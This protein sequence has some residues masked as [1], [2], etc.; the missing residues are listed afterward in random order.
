MSLQEIVN[1]VITQETASIEQAGFSTVLILGTNGNIASRTQEFTAADATLAA[2][3]NGGVNAAEY[4]A[5]VDLK[6]QSPC[7]PTFKIGCIG[8]AKV[9][10]DDAG[11]YTAGDISLDINGTTITESFDTDKDTT[12]T[13]LAATIQALASV[14]TAV[15]AA[16]SHTITITPIA[17]AAIG[18]TNI[19]LTGITGTMVAIAV[20]TTGAATETITNALN[21]IITE[22]TDWYGLVTV[23]RTQADQED[24][25][26]WVEAN[27]RLYFAGDNTQN[28]FD[29]TDALDSTTLPAV[30]KAAAYART[31]VVATLNADTEYPDAALF[32]KLLPLTPG[33]YTAKFKTLAS[34]TADSLTNAQSVNARDKNA[35]TDEP[36]AGKNIIR[37]GTVAEGEYIDIIIFIDWLKARIQEEVYAVLVKNLKVPYTPAGL[38]QIS[39][40]I[41][42]VLRI[43]QN[44]GGIS[45][46]SQDDDGVQNGGFVVTLPSYDDIS[47]VD[48]AN[49]ELN[50]VQF[51]AWLS[52]AIHT[53]NISG[54]VTY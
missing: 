21:S 34:I 35:N 1:V 3:L 51:T 54:V 52:G 8:I 36:I 15:Y 50:N 14:S 28:I 11:T 17:T 22:D 39:S 12:L 20:T 40:A 44:N 30:L 26:D 24:A 27:D 43:G 9:L 23:T 37:E 19:D 10:T 4:K 31:A 32:G 5:A 53:V 7:P 6:A 16:G 47:A 29:V 46:Y 13:N 41:E 18:I 48:K 45:D 49:R 25:A 33:S 2:A 38:V 42:Q